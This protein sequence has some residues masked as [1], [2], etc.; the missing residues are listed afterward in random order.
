MIVSIELWRDIPNFSNV[1]EVSSFGNIRH[2][3]TQQ[4]RTLSKTDRGYVQISLYNGKKIQSIRVHR[5][6]ARV[7]IPNPQGLTEVNHK[8]GDKANNHVDNLEWIT[9]KDNMIH[10]VKTGLHNCNK[11]VLQYDK[12]GKL[13]KRWNSTMDIQR[14]LG[15]FNSRIS[16]NCLG[17]KG[18][19]KYSYGYLWRYEQNENVT[20]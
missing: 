3:R 16:A 15:Y 13:I 17:V 5:V 4:I 18:I 6:V 8:D 11:I 12:Q 7:F 19:G 20:V 1:Y 9:R 14:E 10:A 2:K